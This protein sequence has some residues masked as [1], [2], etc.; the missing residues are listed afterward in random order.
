MS[1]YSRK[2]RR[3]ST[4]VSPNYTFQGMALTYKRPS[5]AMVQRRSV[6]TP[7]PTVIAREAPLLKRKVHFSAPTSAPAIPISRATPFPSSLPPLLATPLEVTF[8]EEEVV[9][10]LPQT[11]PHGLPTSSLEPGTTDQ[12]YPP[13]SLFPEPPLGGEHDVNHE[14]SLQTV[15]HLRHATLNLQQLIADLSASLWAKA[16]DQERHLSSPPTE[17]EHPPPLIPVEDR[18]K[19]NYTPAFLYT[20]GG[21]LD[22]DGYVPKETILD[23]GAS[24]I[25]ISKSFATAMKIDLTNLNAGAEFVTASGAVEHPLGSTKTKVMFTLARGT[26]HQCKA[27]LHV[28]V[29]DTSAY[30]ALLGMEFITAMGGAYDTWTELFKYRWLAADGTTHSHELSAPCHSKT[31]PIIAYACFGGLIHHSEELQ[32][33]QGAH[34]DIIPPED[35][36]GFHTSPFQLAAT[37][38][39]Q[40]AQQ[41]EEDSVVRLRKEVRDT[42]LARRDNAAVKLAAASPLT[43]PALLPSSQWLGD[44]VYGAVPINT[45]VRQLSPQSLRDGLHV[46]ELFGGVGL[47]VLRSA[48]AAGYS[49]KCYTY[50][51]YD[52]ISRRIAAQVLQKLQQQHPEQLPST[53]IQAFDQRLPQSIACIGNLLLSNLITR[54]GPIDILGASWEC[55]SVSRAGKQQGAEDPRFRYFFNMVSIIN[56]IEREQTSS[57]VYILENTYPGE[58]CSPAVIKANNLVQAFIGA[59]V[60]IDA[61]GVGSAAHRVR[62]F[63]SN[64]L[65]PSIIQ[66]ALPTNVLPRPSLEVILKSFHIPTKPGHS[67]HFPFAAHNQVGWERTCMP[68]V[69]SYLRSNAFR[70]KANGSPGEGEVYNI[71]TDKWEEPDVEEKELLLGFQRGETATTNVTDTQRAIRLG[72][73]LDCN[74]MKWLGAF[75]HASQI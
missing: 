63:W 42:N 46:V 10:H 34:D 29:V 19:T 26:I 36:Y 67:D 23:T 47:G 2:K 69:V 31:P 62:L 32:D 20:D 35:D 30:D 27:A 11:F 50:V 4:F 22:L 6:R 74:T 57:C 45:S 51:D 16:T 3:A 68:T 60:L 58:R 18:H 8:E 48:L 7:R 53:A 65:Q 21:A 40:Q 61:A 28:T 56:F 52:P 70:P 41:E 44:P 39:Q 64:M 37:A 33:V 49:I 12:Q 75:L 25:M 66:A 59:P 54:H 1:A 13:T 14:T 15:V 55:Q 72:R 17:P 24:K 9:A 5:P 71:H 73:A 38:L 43:L